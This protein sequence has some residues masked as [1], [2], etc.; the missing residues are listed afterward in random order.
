MKRLFLLGFLLASGCQQSIYGSSGLYVYNGTDKR[1]TVEISGGASPTEFLLRPGTGKLFDAQLAG[2]RIITLKSDGGSDELKLMLEKDTFN[3]LN[4]DGAG[5]FARA[6]VSGMYMDGRAPVKVSE[7]Y[8]GEN[9]ITMRSEVHVPPGERLPKAK[10][11]SP[12]GFNRLAV[13]PCENLEDAYALADYIKE[14][15]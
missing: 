9:L 14:L 11:K 8:T 2:E 15:R 5:C 12:F 1:T 10:P 3:I 4:V 13:V 7:T 6:D